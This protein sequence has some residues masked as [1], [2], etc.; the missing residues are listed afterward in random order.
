MSLE[1]ESL[2]GVFFWVVMPAQSLGGIYRFYLQDRKINQT[3][4][5]QKSGKLRDYLGLLLE[6][7]Y[8]TESVNNATNCFLFFHFHSKH[9]MF[10]P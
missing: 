6:S 3:R 2:H 9:N 8:I 1:T 10:R 4:N 7:L 5:E